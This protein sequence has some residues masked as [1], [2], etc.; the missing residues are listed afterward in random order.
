MERGGGLK[1]VAVQTENMLTDINRSNLE[2]TL[3]QLILLLSDDRF[4]KRIKTTRGLAAKGEKKVRESSHRRLHRSNHFP[5]FFCCSS[6][7]FL[8]TSNERVK[9]FQKAKLKFEQE[10]TASGEAG[11]IGYSIVRPTAFFKSVSG[12]LEV[13]SLVVVVVVCCM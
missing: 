10:L 5:L 11:Q 3:I 1:Y 7:C 4:H 13:Q 8:T 12:Q 9:Q 6:L 2:D